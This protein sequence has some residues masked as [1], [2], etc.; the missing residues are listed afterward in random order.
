[1]TPENKFVVYMTIYSG[2]KLPG[3]YI[4]ST[5]RKKFD[6]GY[7][8]SVLSKK[9]KDTWR[10]ELR[11]NT[12][13]FDTIVIEEFP[14]RKEALSME[15]RLQKKHDVVRSPLFVNMAYAAPN[16]SH[17]RDVS[18]IN[19]PLH[20][21]H[22]GKGNKHWHN[23]MTGERRFCVDCPDGF[24][25]GRNIKTNCNKSRKWYYDPVTLKCRIL[26]HQPDGWLKGRPDLHKWVD[27]CLDVRRKNKRERNE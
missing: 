7:C 15:L 9:Y 5:S 2:D 13:L 14:T 19:H 6:N 21:S 23:P 22:N 17:G 8:G 27:V 26:E 18:G 3:F 16:G 24:I 10:E 1:M 4:G 20:G 12:H 25:A 11:E